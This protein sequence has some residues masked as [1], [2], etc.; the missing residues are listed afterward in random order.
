MA[1]DGAPPAP[2]L[3]H[4]L[5][6]FTPTAHTH[7]R[8]ARFGTKIRE[9]PPVCVAD[10]GMAAC[11][12]AC[13]SSHMSR[14]PGGP[15]ARP[16]PE[17]WRE[18]LLGPGWSARTLQLGPEPDDVATL[19][20]R[21]V[22]RRPLRGAVLYVH[23]FSDYFFAGHSG[24]VWADRGF[25]FYAI[26]LR[27]H[28]R[29]LRPGQLANHTVDLAEYFDDLDTAAAVVRD[30]TAGPLVVLGHS[31]GG[32]TASLWAHA[33]REGGG[34]DLLV[35]NS[36]WFDFNA[37]WFDR[38]VASRLV[39]VLGRVAPTLP[40]RRL[41]PHY[42]RF[43]HRNT[44]GEWDFNLDWKPYD[45]FPARAGF[46]RTVRL[47]HEAV[48]AGLDIACPVLMCCSTESGPST[49]FHSRLDR[50]DSVLNV[51][52]MLS[53]APGLGRDVTIKPIDGGIHD[54]ALSP[55]P[56]RTRYF[57]ATLDWVDERVAEL[58]K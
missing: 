6:R 58:R 57:D 9:I 44:G 55:H 39:K 14:S 24:R 36:P 42:A 38:V 15:G 54:L 46:V 22:A 17:S 19:V 18:D 41:D 49:M 48:K 5:P 35:L 26:D 25:Q 28:G 32:L 53:R 30:A 40:V 1:D 10:R 21:D 3:G 51:A 50:T 27:R 33:R 47:G 2:A 31:T 11:P 34:P 8:F 20:R 43:L 13:H 29:S 37:S 12:R 4:H 45:G 16:S 7:E 52:H 56:A 23:G